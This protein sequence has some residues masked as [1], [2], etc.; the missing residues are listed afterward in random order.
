M[1]HRPLRLVQIGFGHIGMR[2]VH[3][4]L[5][6]PRVALVGVVDVK[7]ERLTLARDIAGDGCLYLRDYRDALARLRPDAAIVSTPNYL[8]GTITRDVLST[9]VHVLCE[10]PLASTVAQAEQCVALAR[11]RGKVLKVGS[12]HRFWRGV[13]SLLKRLEEG[14]VGAVTGVRAEIGYRMP[15]FHSEW[16]READRSGGGTLIDN[17]PHALSVI[18]EIL[19]VAGDDAIARVRC[20]TSHEALGLAVEDCAVGSMVTRRGVPVHLRSTWGDGAYRMNLEVVGTRG[21]LFLDGFDRLEVESADGREEQ[22]F[23]EVPA[24]ESWDLDVQSFVDAIV[25]RV[26]PVGTGAEGLQNLRVIAALYESAARG[27]E[28]VRLADPLTRRG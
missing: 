15:D 9:G 16:Y 24:G 22:S 14:A 21:R 17:S 10:K 2:R 26:R 25:L 4:V 19:R 20:R 6:N 23:R 11:A 12:N 3:T 5:R 27:H 13:G 1:R 8:H 18:E 7:P 28:E